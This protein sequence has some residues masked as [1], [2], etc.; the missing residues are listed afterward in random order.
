[1]PAPKASFIVTVCL[2]FAFGAALRIAGLG[3]EA[4]WHDEVAS[5][6]MTADDLRNVLRTSAR[7]S[8]PPGYFLGLHAWRKVVPAT[9]AWVRGYSALWS[10]VS[11]SLIAG[12]AGW[13]WGRKHALVAL[14]LAAVNPLDIYYAQELRMYTQ[15]NA[16]GILS[17]WMLLW[18]MRGSGGK[19][20]RWIAAL[21][22]VL[23]AVIVLLCHYV[24]LMLLLAQ[25]VA[26]VAYLASRRRWLDVFAY[27][28]FAVAVA[29]LF[30][31]WYAYVHRIHSGFNVENVAWITL[32]PISYYFSFVAQ[33]FFFGRAFTVYQ[34]WWPVTL[35]LATLL[36]SLCLCRA[37][38]RTE[39]D[40]ARGNSPA[41]PLYFLMWMVLGP[42]LMAAIFSYAYRPIF[43]RQ[44]FALFLLPPFLL[45]AAFASLS[46]RQKVAQYALVG[47]AAGIMLCGTILQHRLVH[48]P[49]WRLIK[50][51]WAEKGSPDRYAGLSPLFHFPVANAVQQKLP[52]M[53]KQELQNTDLLRDGT[54]IWIVAPVP[55]TDAATVSMR[56]KLQ[57][58]GTTESLLLTADY[59][60]T[61]VTVMR[62]K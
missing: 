60:V 16:F 23:S 4:M 9:D 57:A 33:E 41:V 14:L 39:A 48:K 47:T 50:P 45:V 13:L 29:A 42:A 53:K 1:M 62:G 55:L 20:V 52:H 35:I 17:L 24:G 30:G 43:D 25:G 44:R 51:L 27:V 18:W 32:S 5:L 11:I 61:S 58:L 37:R 12:L 34:R 46:V 22:Y 26:V 31:G 3:K 2:I 10:L 40:P 28:S 15:T 8:T 21:S 54:S 59:D 56:E 36:V 38:R 6:R 7:D 19:G 49:D